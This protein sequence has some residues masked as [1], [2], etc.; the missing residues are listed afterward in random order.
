MI[1]FYVLRTNVSDM[2]TQIQICPTAFQDIDLVEKFD[3]QAA[4][5]MLALAHTVDDLKDLPKSGFR[6]Y[7]YH[8]GELKVL[9]KDNG[10]GRLHIQ[11]YELTKDGKV[12]I[13]S[14]TQAQCWNWAKGAMC[15][16]YRDCD[17][18]N[19]HPEILCQICDH[20]DLPCDNLRRY[21]EQRSALI[22]ETG[23]DKRDFKKLFFSTVLYHPQ[24]TDEQLKRKL[25][26]YKLQSEP[27]LFTALRAEM[28]EISR[29]LL[30]M[31]PCYMQEAIKKKG[32]GYFNLAGTAVSLLI[33]TAE[34]RVV[35]ALYQFWAEVKQ[36]Q[37][38]ALIHDG[39]H[40]NLKAQDSDLPA[41]SD[42][43]HEHTGFRLRV[44]FK[45]WQTHPE[46]DRV[47]VVEDMS[48]CIT[49]GLK[50]LQGRI[51]RCL[52]RVWFRDDSYQWFS[53]KDDVLRLIAAA[54]E[55]LPIFAQRK[56]C[57]VS[58]AR[59]VTTQAGIGNKHSVAKELYDAAP[60]DHEFIDRIRRENIGRLVFLDGYYDFKTG[61]F[62]S[63][64][65]DCLARVP[66][67]FPAH[68]EADIAEVRKRV[69]KPIMGN[70]Q[71]S[72]MSWL[73]RGLAGHVV[74]KSWGCMLGERDCGKSV[75]HGLCE[76]ALGSELVGTLN[77]ESFLVKQMAD[78]DTSK[79]LGFLLD[80]E[81]CRLVWTNESPVK[82]GMLLDGSLVKKFASGGDSITARALYAKACTFRLSGRLLFAAN[83]LPDCAPSDATEKLDYFQA[84]HKFVDLMDKRCGD[85]IHLPK[86]DSIK[87]F[88]TEP[89][90]RG[91]FIHM[92]LA[93][94]ENKPIRTA[95]MDT[96]R[97]EF[98]EAGTDD[99]EQFY[100]MFEATGKDE[101]TIPVQEVARMVRDCGMGVTSR[102]YSRWL[103][104][105]GC[106][107][108]ARETNRDGKRVR[109]IR[110]LKRKR[111]GD[112]IDQLLAAGMPA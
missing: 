51:V 103:R 77:T 19:A 8:N 4:G 83:D 82:P 1:I 64:M 5:L 35:R 108:T 59:H 58:I 98:I 56:G 70:I 9:Y 28:R 89:R 61:E 14:I 79:A 72:L 44:E 90:V 50:E 62:C 78:P 3:T 66:T 47:A 40:V 94:Y 20:Y 11:A 30:E 88:C 16:M 97:A 96:M 38:G 99:R 24:C 41:A 106:D 92:L 63:D 15:T 110:G 27:A 29:R 91:A 65:V 107:T 48:D 36:L 100:S 102:R 34:K 68:V 31:Q 21:N 93:A 67:P 42:Y 76:N 105:D 7:T 12:Y 111:N 53:D 6:N 25:E 80:V 57:Y 18:V 104:A 2:P 46:Y 69:T 23:L 74:D 112:P 10:I 60:V 87:E 13:D 22:E 33:Q 49:Y 39:V 54:V 26:K 101:D 85:G 32:E 75:L 17:V 95:A 86:D 81:N 52:N 84:P 55:H 109:V 43:I 71:E 73:S 37:V 45:P